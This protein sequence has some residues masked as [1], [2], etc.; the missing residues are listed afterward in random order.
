MMLSLDTPLKDNI[1]WTFFLVP[2]MSEHAYTHWSL[3]VMTICMSKAQ[4]HELT[5]N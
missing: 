3:S 4:L 2:L 1:Q 5:Y